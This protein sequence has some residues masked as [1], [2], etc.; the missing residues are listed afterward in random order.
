VPYGTTKLPLRT[1]ALSNNGVG[2]DN[3]DASA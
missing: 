3:G 1:Q 2:Y